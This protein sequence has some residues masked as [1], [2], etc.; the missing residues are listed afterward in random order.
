MHSRMS[1][2]PRFTSSILRES[3]IKKTQNVN[4]IAVTCALFDFGIKK[5]KKKKKKNV[6][7]NLAFPPLYRGVHRSLGTKNGICSFD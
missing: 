7:P 1:T 4:S 3:H 6:Q 5:K 2:V